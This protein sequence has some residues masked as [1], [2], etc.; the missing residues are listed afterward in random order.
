MYT[1]IGLGDQPYDNLIRVRGR[2]LESAQGI[3]EL[4]LAQHKS[5][6]RNSIRQ[7]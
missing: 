5:R 3:S 2:P 1:D 6:W 4:L 7:E